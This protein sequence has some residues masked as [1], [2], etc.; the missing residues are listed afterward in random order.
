MKDKLILLCFLFCSAFIFSQCSDIGSDKKDLPKQNFGGF[1]SQVK[2]GEHLVTV[3]G[4][5]DCHSPKKMTPQGP[6]ID[7]DRAFSGHPSQMPP[8]DIDRKEV[9]SK[10]LV[11]TT[12]TLTSWVGPWGVSYAANLT[13][14]ATGIGNWQESNFITALRQGKFKGMPTGRSL[15]PPMPWE[16]FKEMSDDEIKAIFAY[17]K[18]VKPIT[19]LVPEYQPPVTAAK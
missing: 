14:D 8:P 16:F 11:V 4:C 7:Q 2:W 6:V 1:E 17:L 18:S 9:E 19:N 5:A 15:M 3:G 12:P 10:G 13:P